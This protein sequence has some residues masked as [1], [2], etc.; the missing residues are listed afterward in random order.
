MIFSGGAGVRFT[1]QG[2]ASYLTFDLLVWCQ[3]IPPFSVYCPVQCSIALTTAHFHI[4]AE[5]SDVN[6]DFTCTFYIPACVTP[7]AVAWHMQSEVY[8]WMWSILRKT[9]STTLH[10]TGQDSTHVC[11]HIR[12]HH[13]ASSWLITRW[14][15]VE[16]EVQWWAERKDWRVCVFGVCLYERGG[17]WLGVSS[18]T[19]L[20]PFN[21]CGGLHL[22]KWILQS[23]YSALRDKTNTWDVKDS[24]VSKPKFLF[25]TEVYLKKGA[26]N[27][28][29][30]LGCI[31][32]CPLFATISDPVSQRQLE[33]LAR[34]C[35][36]VFDHQPR[37]KHRRPFRKNKAG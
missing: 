20:F 12:M 33:N 4:K 21:P 11:S 32:G 19:F 25:T 17:T 6:L 8:S 36:L 15:T 35:V 2:T 23:V 30:I 10:Y 26:C 28:N 7:G 29:F 13:P 1:K 37:C 27:P 22:R 3:E 14:E 24:I 5:Q 34:R 31:C 16:W 9:S 18:L